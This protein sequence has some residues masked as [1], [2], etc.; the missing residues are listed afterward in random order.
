MLNF[1]CSPL[2]PKL[3]ISGRFFSTSTLSLP[4]AMID[5]RLRIFDVTSAQEFQE[6]RMAGL[7]PRPDII[8]IPLADLAAQASL[9]GTEK[10]RPLVFYCK[11]GVRAGMAAG[12]AQRAGF[13]NAFALT[14]AQTVAS[15]L[16]EFTNK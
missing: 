11:H 13:F 6:T 5:P 12:F 14:D 8:H 1:R 15:L 7:L 10:D 16:K 3:S 2:R 9:L 4:Q